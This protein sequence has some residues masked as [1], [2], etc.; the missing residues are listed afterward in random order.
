MAKT[1]IASK[2]WLRRL[3]VTVASKKKEMIKKIVNSIYPLSK[4]S[5]QEI[6]SLIKL[7]D[8]E[9]GETFIKKKSEI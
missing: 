9:K 6:N 1:F 7:E 2:S 4:K 5:L 8:W 3:S